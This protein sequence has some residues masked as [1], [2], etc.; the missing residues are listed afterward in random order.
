MMPPSKKTIL[1]YYEILGVSPSATSSE[2]RKAYLK[3]SLQH[4]PDKNPHNVAAAQAK[5]VELGRAYEV[6]KDESTRREYD[7]QQEL[8]RYGGGGGGG[9]ASSS[10]S[11]YYPTPSSS[12]TTGEAAEFDEFDPQAY[13]N[14][15]DF[16]D[17]TVAGMSEA[18]LAAAVG[19]AA[20]IGS[21]VGSLVGSHLA[22]GATS[23][24]TRGAAAGGGAGGA[25]IL[26]TAGSMVGSMVASELA[27]SSVR[28]LHQSSKQRI[29]YKRACRIATD[30]GEPLPEPPAPTQW[31]QLVGK[32][33]KAVQTATQ[34]PEKAVQS[35][36]KLWNKARAGVNAATAFA[37]ANTHGVGSTGSRPS[38]RGGAGGTGSTGRTSFG[39]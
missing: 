17:E 29:E 3:L 2:I 12:T 21:L 39:R 5:F 30:R 20:M 11:Y 22:H 18:D 19:A 10:S 33:V 26:T 15:R 36:G 14:Y 16:F 9:G 38:S 28:S 27:A 35:F 13:E 32:T 1:S 4:H 37:D 7:Q 34:N 31:D 8:L 6:L 23:H 25:G 24:G